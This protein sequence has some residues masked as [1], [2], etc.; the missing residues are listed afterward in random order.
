MMAVKGCK[1]EKKQSEDM[2]MNEVLRETRG[3]P[4]PAPCQGE[5]KKTT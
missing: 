1:S 3:A 2:R 5:A 4:A